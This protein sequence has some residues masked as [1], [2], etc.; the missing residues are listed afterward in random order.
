MTLGKILKLGLCL[1]EAGMTPS[2][3]LEEMHK[4]VAFAFLIKNSGAGEMAESVEV[5]DAKSDDLCFR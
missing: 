5:L 2:C 3:C 4:A 1:Q